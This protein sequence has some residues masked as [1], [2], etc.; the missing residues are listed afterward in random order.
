MTV[1]ARWYAAS[2]AAGMPLV[3]AVRTIRSVEPE[4]RPR[5]SVGSDRLA[6]ASSASVGIVVPSGSTPDS[7]AALAEVPAPTPARLAVQAADSR[8]SG[9]SVAAF[10]ARPKR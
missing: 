3:E 1:S 5:P 2:A 10:W 8:A 7:P 6:G 4:V 9:T